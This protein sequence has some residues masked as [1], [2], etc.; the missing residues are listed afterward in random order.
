[1]NLLIEERGRSG[2]SFIKFERRREGSLRLGIM[3]LLKEFEFRLFSFSNFEIQT[4]SVS[5]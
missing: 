3:L 4:L 2:E 5:L 1:M